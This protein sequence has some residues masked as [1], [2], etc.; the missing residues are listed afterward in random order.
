MEM[1]DYVA[2]TN[3]AAKAWPR[4]AVK[5]PIVGDFNIY[6]QATDFNRW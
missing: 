6:L 1:A 5:Q 3:I 4:A 2:A